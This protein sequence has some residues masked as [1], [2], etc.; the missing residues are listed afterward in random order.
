LRNIF[1]LVCNHD[2]FR[3][4]GQVCRQ[5]FYHLGARNWPGVE[6]WQNVL[7]DPRVWLGAREYLGERIG[8]RVLEYEGQ[9]DER[10][11]RTVERCIKEMSN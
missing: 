4:L 10:S 3:A 2:R 7:S 1:G 9:R 8:L 5:F 11:T 6:N